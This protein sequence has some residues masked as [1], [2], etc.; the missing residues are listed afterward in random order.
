M[1]GSGAATGAW[2][3]NV[4]AT[5]NGSSPAQSGISPQSPGASSPPR[6]ERLQRQ[7][8]AIARV[9]AVRRAWAERL[10]T[11]GIRVGSAVRLVA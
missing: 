11:I 10:R 2:R 5:S 4:H 3:K 8:E 9:E 1:G 7:A 6:D